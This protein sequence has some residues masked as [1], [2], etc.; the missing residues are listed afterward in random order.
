M[1]QL[2]APWAH[3][4]HRQQ[5]ASRTGENEQISM[6]QIGHNNTAMLCRYIREGSLFRENAAPEAISE[7][8]EVASITLDTLLYDQLAKLWL[9]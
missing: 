6:Q 9:I 4:C 7:A 1:P 3:V 5:E 8:R 2:P